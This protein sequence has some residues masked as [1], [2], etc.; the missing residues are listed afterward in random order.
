MYITYARFSGPGLTSGFSATGATSSSPVSVTATPASATIASRRAS[1]RAESNGTYAAP[2]FNTPSST[3]ISAADRSKRTPTSDSGP[4]PRS[5]SPY[6]TP[7]AHAFSSAYVHDPSCPTTATASGVRAACAS[8]RS[9]R[10]PSGTARRVSF[11]PCRTIRR[12][13]SET[14]SMSPTRASGSAAT[15]SSTRTRR[16]ARARAVPSSNRSAAYWISPPNPSGEPSASRSSAS[17]TERSK[18]AVAVSSG[19][20]GCTCSPGRFQSHSLRSWG[21]LCRLNITWKRGCRESE[22]AG[23][24]SSTSRSNGTSWWAYAARSVSRTRSS[25]SA[26]DGS[27]LTSVRSTS[28]LTKNPT[29]LSTAASLRP[30]T[31]VPSGMSVPAPTLDSSTASAACATMNIVTPCRRAS[32]DRRACTSASVRTGTAPPRKDATAGRG[33]SL[34]RESSSGRSARAWRQWSSCP[35]RRLS[36]SPRSPRTSRC[37]S[38]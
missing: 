2:A 17:S 18:R 34:G 30:A 16:A 20:M 23:F 13:A 26:N 33:W 9:T 8:N 10:V 37:H 14:T 38:A 35:V 36:G 21:A 15:C 22:R 4:T 1:G 7:F 19:R 32:S 31:A 3:G 11:H 5:M 29:M 28:V 27:P 12:S 25:S 6:A 24:R